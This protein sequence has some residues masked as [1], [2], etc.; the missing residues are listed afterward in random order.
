MVSR[1][2]SRIEPFLHDI[3]DDII[4]QSL[5]GD[6]L[7]RYTDYFRGALDI[8]FNQGLVPVNSY[9][10]L[11][12]FVAWL[13]LDKGFSEEEHCKFTFFLEDFE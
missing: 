3:L 8:A 6:Q 13:E 2:D 10:F 5:F 1:I 7:Q 4:N 11:F 12:N 9:I